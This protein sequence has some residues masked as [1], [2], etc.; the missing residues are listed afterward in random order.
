MRPTEYFT[1]QDRAT[2]QGI[3]REDGRVATRNFIGVLT[4]V[5]CSATG[6]QARRRG[7]REWRARRRTRMSTAWSR[8]CTAP[9]AAW[10]PRARASMSCSASLW[11]YPAPSELRRRAADRPRLRGGADPLPAG[12]LWHQGD[13]DLPI[14]DHPGHRRH[15]RHH[16]G[17][18]EARARPCCPRPTRSSARRCRP[19]ICRSACN[20]AAPTATRA[21]PPTRRSG[22]A[23]DLLVRHGGTAILSRDAGDLRRR[24]PAAPAARVDR[25][26]G[27]KLIDA[28]QL[29]GGLHQPQRR[30]DEQQSL[31]RQQG[32]RPHHHPREV[33]GRRGQ[34]RHRPTWSMS[35]N[36][37]SRSRRKGFVFMDTPGYDP[38]SGHRPGGERRQHHLLHHRA[39][40]RPSAASRHRA[41][42]SPPTPP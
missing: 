40:A 10:R 20:A 38:V 7:V 13:R 2:F 35:T 26:I 11:G 15:P 14:H 34:R 8:W 39:A 41:S 6:R 22:A 31:A 19:S 25:K 32:R 9:A 12:S 30:R 24:A 16:R 37:P 5:N 18:R 36:T 21:S 28:H 4:T 3:V 29:V 1:G 42:S 27:E 33:A 23:A 17:R